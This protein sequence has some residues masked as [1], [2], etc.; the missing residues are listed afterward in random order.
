VR[1]ARS[2]RARFRT[3]VGDPNILPN[4]PLAS[5]WIDQRNAASLE[6]LWDAASDTSGQLLY[7]PFVSHYPR[8]GQAEAVTTLRFLDRYKAL[9]LETDG[10]GKTAQVL[11]VAVVDQDGVPLFASLS[12]PPDLSKLGSHEGKRAHAANGITAD[13]VRVAPTLPDVWPRLVEVLTE[14]NTGILA[15]FNGDFDFRIIRNAAARED[16]YVP[17]LSGLCLMKLATAYFERDFYL[18]LD[19]AGMLAGMARTA[20][21]TAHRALGDARYAARI[22]RHLR[23]L[24]DGQQKGSG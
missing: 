3:L 1:Y 6:D 18:S 2:I 17:A 22:V 16:V 13:V 24:A 4:V 5:F 20:E 19:E 23:M 21:E 8:W 12:C 11:D 7:S 15:A 14:P 9:D 10:L